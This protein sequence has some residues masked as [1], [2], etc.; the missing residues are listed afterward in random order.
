MNFQRLKKISINKRS[1]SSLWIEFEQ[2][3]VYYRLRLD[4]MLKFENFQWFHNDFAFFVIE[5]FRFQVIFN[6]N[7]EMTR[8]FIMRFARSII[9]KYDKFATM[10]FDKSAIMKFDKLVIM[11]FDKLVTMKFDKFVIK[12]YTHS[13]W[14]KRFFL[15]EL[16]TCLLFYLFTWKI[17]IYDSFIILLLSLNIWLNISLNI[18]L[19]ILLN[20]SLNSSLN[21]SLNLLLLLSMKVCM[22]ST[23]ILHWSYILINAHDIVTQLSYLQIYFCYH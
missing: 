22:H 10:G 13:H 12:S 18:L 19:N 23:S 3:I 4:V 2:K 6:D 21:L 1:K 20:L 17:F 16:T 11:R 15:I 5:N 9:M 8:F 14:I 7:L